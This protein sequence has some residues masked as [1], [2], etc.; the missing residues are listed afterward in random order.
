MNRVLFTSIFCS[1]ACN[2]LPSDSQ[3]SGADNPA[4]ETMMMIEGS[5]DQ[6]SEKQ[7]MVSNPK[8]LSTPSVLNDHSMTLQNGNRETAAEF[9]ADAYFEGDDAFAKQ[10]YNLTESMELTNEEVAQL[11][12]LE[13]QMDCEVKNGIVGEFQLEDNN[14]RGTFGMV[15]FGLEN[16]E[17]VDAVRGKVYLGKSTGILMD[18]NNTMIAS[19]ENT[20]SAETW[21]HAQGVGHWK[22]EGAL[23]PCQL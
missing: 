19:L 16:D 5:V 6:Q 8:G 7:T 20:S 23:W 14:Q 1:V 13:A 3:L 9:D 17:Q 15:V 22:V 12:N 11:V 18:T 21:E 2:E 4:E 10:L